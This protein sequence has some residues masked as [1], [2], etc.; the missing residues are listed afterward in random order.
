[1]QEIEYYFPLQYIN[2]NE[3]KLN[4]RFET[5]GFKEFIENKLVQNGLIKTFESKA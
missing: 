2:H 1:M 4:T 3:F 5:E